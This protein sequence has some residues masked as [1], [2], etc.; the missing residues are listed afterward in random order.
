MGFANTYNNELAYS[1]KLAVTFQPMMNLAMLGNDRQE[2]V[3]GGMIT[4][5]F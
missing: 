3:Y 2:S 1:L 4:A 5:R